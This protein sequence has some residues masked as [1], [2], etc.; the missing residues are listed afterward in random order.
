MNNAIKFLKEFSSVLQGQDKEDLDTKISELD[1]LLNSI[2]KE[3]S[4]F[5]YK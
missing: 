4:L 3:T 5:M 1:Y 2:T